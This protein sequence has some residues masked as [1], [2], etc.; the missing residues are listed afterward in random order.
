MQGKR[1]STLLLTILLLG[2]PAG[3]GATTYV[4]N[5]GFLDVADGC[6]DATCAS[7]SL[8]LSSPA[9]LTGSISVSGGLLDLALSVAGISL[10]GVPAGADDGETASFSGLSFA[11]S[12]LS[13]SG[14]PGFF[15]LDAGQTASVSGD[16]DGNGF[17]AG[18]VA[19]S[20]TCTE[21]AGFL[22]CGLTF[23]ESGFSLATG[24]GDTRWFAM[25]LDPV[26]SVPE[27]AA[28]VMAVTGVLG[29][30]S[31]RRRSLRG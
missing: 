12:G 18:A 22:T 1:F 14:V 21:A 19:V 31:Y 17:A 4:V 10:D 16:L 7:P 2:A 9:P 23:G 6:T 13:V 28:A 20:G 15:A 11:G 29:L 26:G 5:S 8:V 24:D 27:P 3:A 25:T 30:L